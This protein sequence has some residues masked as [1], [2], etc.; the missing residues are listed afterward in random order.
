MYDPVGGGDVDEAGVFVAWGV[1][2]VG[3]DLAAE[4]VAVVVTVIPPPMLVSYICTCKA[5]DRCR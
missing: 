3:D 2:F 4:P 1:D 5:T